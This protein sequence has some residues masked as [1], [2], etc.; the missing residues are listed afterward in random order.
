MTKKPLLPAFKGQVSKTK[1]PGQTRSSLNA[2][3]MSHRNKR[4]PV[5]LPKIKLPEIKSPDSR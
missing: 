5:T 4:I 2:T 1:Y 3:E